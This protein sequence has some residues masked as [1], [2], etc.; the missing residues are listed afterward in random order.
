MAPH[1]TRQAIAG[2]RFAGHWLDGRR[3]L[4][5]ML[6]LVGTLASS[7]A[8]P[9]SAQSRRVYC[10]RHH[11]PR[12]CVQIPTTAQRPPKSNQQGPATLTPSGVES[13]GGLG[14]GPG[15][16][17]L[18]AVSWARSQL[19]LSEWAW[20]CERFVEEAYGTRYRFDTARQAAST[21]A[22]HH[23]PIADAPA[24]S[25]VYFAADHANRGLGHVGLSLGK[26]KMISALARVE[27][28]D[29]ARSRYWQ[30]LYLGWADAPSTWP[31]RIPLPPGPTTENPTLTVQITA[32]A[33]GS[34]LSGTVPLAATAIGAT[35]VQFY[36]YYA[37][38]PKNAS[39]RA[40]HAL[41]AGRYVNGA[42]YLD[43][44]TTQVSDQG[45]PPWGTVNVAAVALGDTGAQTA[46]RDYRRFSIDNTL[47]VE[48]PGVPV[49][50]VP[51]A[52]PVG[53]L[54]FANRLTASTV[55]VIGWAQ[56]ADSPA[57]AVTV[58]GLV[59]GVA[60]GQGLADQPRGDVGPHGFNF[61][62]TTDENSGTACVQ[63]TNIGPG[64]DAQLGNCL[65]ILA[66]GDLN[67]D[68]AVNCTDLDI[69]KAHYGQTGDY[70][71]GDLNDDGT[72][73]LFDLSI[74]LS[75]LGPAGNSCPSS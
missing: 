15:N 37:S 65:P 58:T 52:P 43:W 7:T 29:V 64:A 9:A 36:A 50:Q 70:S 33:F 3:V 56:D 26:G 27:V 41:G 38:D 72:V 73:N 5:L 34:T 39:T 6:M 69:L 75:R 66:F 2:N 18:T 10:T 14:G 68:G 54:L 1:S 61:T 22:L 21:L 12:G 8:R 48:P 23:D 32:P 51:G 35:G 46:T 60:A 31:G 40:W 19:G 53:A 4:M 42:W 49:P 57:S 13:G 30:G 47:P 74:M 28:T 17:R 45:N 59:N 71:A 63:G 25:L 62:V 55:Q 67:G 20:H 24:G 16:H 11:H 44:D